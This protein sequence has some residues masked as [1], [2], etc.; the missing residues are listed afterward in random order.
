MYIAGSRLEVHR[1]GIMI[2]IE[3]LPEVVL[4]L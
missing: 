1:M 2:Y 3:V 4:L